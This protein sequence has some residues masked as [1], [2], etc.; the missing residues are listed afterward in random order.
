MTGSLILGTVIISLYW[1]FASGLYV[2]PSPVGAVAALFFGL[3]LLWRAAARSPAEV[4]RP[5]RAVAAVAIVASAVAAIGLPWPY[6]AGPILVLAGLLG[7]TA[8]AGRSPRTRPFWHALAL[9]GFML[10]AESI[11]L[12]AYVWYFSADHILAYL[13][14]PLW[15]LLK[16]FGHEGALGPAGVYIPLMRELHGFPLTSER[17]GLFQL[18][19]ISVGFLVAVAAA[20]ELRRSAVRLILWGIFIAAVYAIVRYAVVVTAY[21]YLMHR[22]GYYDNLNRV[23]VFWSPWWT[24]AT[25]LPIAWCLAFISPKAE[26]L[27]WLEHL[28]S[29]PPP[30]ARYAWAAP[31]TAL[32]GAVAIVAYL[33]VPEPAVRKA[34]RVLVDEYHSEWE[35]TTRPYDTKWYGQGSGYNYY[36]IYDF[37]AHY[38]KMD[39]LEAPITSATLADCDVLVVKTPTSR[40]EEKEIAAIMDFVR[41]GGGL[42]LIGEHTNVFGTGE[43]INALAE[44][45]GFEFRYDCLFDT[46]RKFEQLYYPPH[47]LPHPI[48]Q[49]L[50]LFFFQVSCSIRPFCLLG[51][52]VIVGTR[53]KALPVD[54]HA[55]NFYPQ[56]IDRSDMDFGPFVEMWGRDWGKGRVLGFGDSTCFSNFCAFQPGKPEMLLA[57]I[58]WLNRRDRWGHWK[59]LWLV[60]GLAAV[61]AAALLAAASRCGVRTASLAILVVAGA[62]P[63]L[64]FGV[65]W[66]NATTYGLPLPRRPLVRVLFERE[67][68]DYELPIK[69]FVQDPARSYDVF[70]Q[71]TMRVGVF[72]FVGWTLEES[73]QKGDAVVLVRPRRDFSEREIE[74]L[75]EFVRRGGALI[76][77][78]TPTIAGD[79]ARVLLRAFGISLD[80]RRT[81]SGLVQAGDGSDFT[82]QAAYVISGGEPLARGAGGEVLAVS[83]EFGRGRVV[84]ASFAERFCDQNMGGGWS[85]KPT[86]KLLKVYRMEYALVR[87][88]LGKK[89]AARP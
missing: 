43:R 66:V 54:Y 32:V 7:W 40:Y 21:L 80:R 39:R 3:L 41:R 38:Y 84:V 77:L 12:P 18:K 50:P 23:D 33:A 37:L 8:Y 26:R 86:A 67:H 15:G 69:G 52:R 34:G 63:L 6:R 55:Q 59:Q 5:S 27:D 44:R 62:V 30:G 81:Y 36:C 28:L 82:V 24:A 68:C 19:T 42:F 2:P 31:L 83:K 20:P 46:V 1:S 76:V 11:V 17:L 48:V 88:A 47:L 57:S 25:Y 89:L 16:L 73:V 75:Q 53:L 71:W 85:I 61:L 64:A 29:I 65:R 9:G 70:Y 87:Q 58:E 4:P 60:L 79:S 49:S 56:V 74:M 14:W 51:E 35:K 78:D 22:M 10:V 45:F 72:P 13:R